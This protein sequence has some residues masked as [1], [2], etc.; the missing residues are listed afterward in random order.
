[1]IKYC[2]TTQY[3]C[4]LEALRDWMKSWDGVNSPT[5]HKTSQRVF[6]VPIPKT[7][8]KTTWPFIS[9][10]SSVHWHTAAAT[11]RFKPMTFLSWGLCSIVLWSP[12]KW[13][14]IISLRQPYL[15]VYSYSI[16]IAALCKYLI[17]I[18]SILG[19]CRSKNSIINV[20]LMPSEYL[21]NISVCTEMWK[22]WFFMLLCNYLLHHNTLYTHY[23]DH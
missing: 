9:S 7:F 23:E 21:V 10:P 20:T 12:N 14:S 4:T 22:V 19:K 15:N 13:S 11:A 8:P 1:M 5:L 18:I 16:L 2:F 3:C 6:W 17:N